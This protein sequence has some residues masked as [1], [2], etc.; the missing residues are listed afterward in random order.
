[1]D[2]KI[3][4][5]I[6]LL[7]I[8]C[9]NQRDFRQHDDFVKYVNEK[10]MIDAEITVDEKRISRNKFCV[11]SL[12]NL[13]EVDGSTFE[14]LVQL[15]ILDSIDL[16]PRDTFGIR[17]M[18]SVCFASKLENDLDIYYCGT[19]SICKHV[20]NYLFMLINDNYMPESGDSN[21]FK[22]RYLILVNCHDGKMISS[23]V[24]AC[25]FQ[26]EF[27]REILYTRKRGNRFI[28]EKKE[29]PFDVLFQENRKNT[30]FVP[31]QMTRME[32]EINSKGKIILR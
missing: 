26:D 29:E 12:E 22:N 24:V 14:F 23:V 28:I 6:S 10:E 18:D 9:G 17:Y 27:S 32:F 5:L 31:L 15:P 7:Y 21:Q 4:L 19:F 3:V 8:A 16:F 13:Q 2:N 25:C 30:S 1:M 20:D 11:E